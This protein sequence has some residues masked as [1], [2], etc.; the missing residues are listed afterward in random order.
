MTIHTSPLL[1]NSVVRGSCQC[2][3]KIQSRFGSVSNDANLRLDRSDLNVG[4][5][6]GSGSRSSYSFLK[7][8]GI[9]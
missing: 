1:A 3:A 8:K 2:W 7:G 9:I 4:V 6:L 5:G